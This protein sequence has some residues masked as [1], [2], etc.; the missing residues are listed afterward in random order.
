MN[1]DPQALADAMRAQADRYI[2][3]AL[4]L[5]MLSQIASGLYADAMQLREAAKRIER[6]EHQRET[7][8]VAV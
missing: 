2:R 1:L 7:E 8:R 4:A 6:R 3:E 5:P